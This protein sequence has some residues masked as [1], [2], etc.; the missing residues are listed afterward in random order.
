MEVVA[1]RGG[2]AELLEVEVRDRDDVP[3]ERAQLAVLERRVAVVARVLAVPAVVVV[4]VRE[5]II[6]KS[7]K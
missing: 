1:P 5:T 7:F 3:A 2:A 6:I 4:D